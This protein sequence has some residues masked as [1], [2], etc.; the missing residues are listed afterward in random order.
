VASLRG[1]SFTVQK[2]ELTLP[3][4]SIPLK[5]SSQRLGAEQCF[6]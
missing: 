2:M 4:P 1:S 5:S 6:C 3:K